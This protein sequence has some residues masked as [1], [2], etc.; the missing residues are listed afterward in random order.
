MKIKKLVKHKISFLVT[1]NSNLYLSKPLESIRKYQT[2]LTYKQFCVHV[3]T[4]T[5]E[6][7]MQHKICLK[8]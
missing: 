3:N 7:H 8:N 2:L 4:A 5:Q 1:F 6:Q